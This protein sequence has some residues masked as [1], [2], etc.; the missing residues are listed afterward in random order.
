MMMD[1]ITI[2]ST[3]KEK[4]EHKINEKPLYISLDLDFI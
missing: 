4:N 1:T 2:S 3:K